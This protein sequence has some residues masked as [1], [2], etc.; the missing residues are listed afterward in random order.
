MGLD[1]LT[2][3][4][5]ESY[6]QANRLGELVFPHGS[7]HSINWSSGT[8]SKKKFYINL[9]ELFDLILKWRINGRSVNIEDV[10]AII[11]FGSAVRYPCPK[12]FSSLELWRKCFAIT[13]DFDNPRDADFLVI[14]EHDLI[15]KPVMGPVY[16][17]LEYGR[18]LVKGGIH[19]V[20]RSINQITRG[21][22]TGSDTVSISGLK[23]GV[24]LFYD[25]DFEGFRSCWGIERG[26]P[27]GV[28][29]Q[30]W[31]EK[32]QGTIELR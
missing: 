8:V 9:A 7:C 31:H 18:A 32:L 12:P 13:P 26:N 28:Q 5:L 29:W 17:P 25:C 24:P 30:E 16:E 20:N 15:G 4:D 6:Y 2:P 10:V 21:I 3:K 14:T 27:Y 23:E 11:A 19:L 1:Q 22:R